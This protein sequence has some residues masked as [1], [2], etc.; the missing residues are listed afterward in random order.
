MERKREER[1]NKEKKVFFM[2]DRR[3][4]YF[5][6]SQKRRQ[7]SRRT[8]EAF[9]LSFLVRQGMLALVALLLLSACG[10]SSSAAANPTLPIR[11]RQ[12]LIN[13]STQ[14]VLTDGRGFALYFYLPD[15]PTRS[16]CTGDCAT[17]WPPL[18]AQTGETPTSASSLPGTLSVQQTVNGAQVEYNKH[19]LYTYANDTSP[20]QVTGNGVSGWYVATPD[21][22]PPVS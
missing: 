15:L 14:T 17:T 10:S 9:H 12:V 8:G 19:L 21:L 11:T 4:K 1:E 13:G 3:T 6:F 22:K 5:L 20:G 18:L 16:A 7:S 2:I